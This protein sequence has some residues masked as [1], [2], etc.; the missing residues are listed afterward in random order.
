MPRVEDA[1]NG[2][3]SDRRGEPGDAAAIASRAHDA[4]MSSQTRLL[5]AETL[6]KRPRTLRELSKLTRLSVPGVL[7]HLEAMGKAGFIR[8]E[9]LATRALP[10]RKM[11]SLKGIKVMDFSV[12]DTSIF[13][14][15]S[16]STS[17]GRTP[18]DP[19]LLSMEILVGRRAIR[20]KAR[21][22][23]RSID[24]LAETEGMLQRAIGGMNLTDIE[25]LILE[26][27]LTEETVE[28]GVRALSRFYGIED[29]RS[30]DKALAKA[31][32]NVGK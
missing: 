5:I 7:R 30:I 14:V 6:S 17:K 22:L 26:V 32:R 20:E 23:A 9:K 12:G 27:V 1:Q 25:R 24:G 11:Y 18:E 29:R 16:D 4:L 15:T 28:E 19:E 2:R 3:S 13:R 8:E 31:K 10:V 21:R